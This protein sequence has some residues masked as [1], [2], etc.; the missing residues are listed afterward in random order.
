MAKIFITGGNGQ[1]GRAC[2]RFFSKNH[3]VVTTDIQEMD[4]TNSDSIL[5]AIGD[6]K[7]D[8]IVNCAAYTAV[9]RAESET[10]LAHRLNVI[11]PSK[12]AAA[13]VLFRARLIHIS[14]DY[15][16]DGNRQFPFPWSEEDTPNPQTVYG[17]TKLDGEN[18]VINTYGCDGIVLRTAWLYSPTGHNF[19]KTMLRLASSSPA[20]KIHKIVND[21]F[22]CPT[23]AS[24]LAKQIL[25]IIESPNYLDRGV[26]HAV[27]SGC[28]SWYH[29]ATRFLELMNIDTTNFKPCT[30]EEFPTP[31]KRPRNS[32]LAVDK[33]SSKNMY[34][35]VD[36][37]TALKNYVIEHGQTVYK[38]VLASL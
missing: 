38:D 12:L 16:F 33:L 1:L 25:Y 34:V 35:M 36:W 8:Y 5:K 37:E 19:L 15:V 27:C 17:R 28:T 21:Q 32:V 29:F 6:F 20:D 4:I 3:Q 7:P 14:T 2:K 30:T 10:E 18:A 31:A 22:G 13:A 9:D 11:G 23:S 26:Y 24:E